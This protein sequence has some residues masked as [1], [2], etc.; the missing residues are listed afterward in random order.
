MPCWKTIGPYFD[1]RGFKYRDSYRTPEGLFGIKL[2]A[3]I[4]GKASIAVKASRQNVGLPTLPVALPLRVQ[5]Q[6]SSGECWEATYTQA[7]FNNS[8]GFGA[9]TD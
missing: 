9:S 2:K 4:P 3:G 7:G 8:L 6:A 1:A 5:L